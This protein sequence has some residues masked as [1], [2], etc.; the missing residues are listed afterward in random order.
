M[1]LALTLLLVP[2]FAHATG[3]YGL[4]IYTRHPEEVHYYGRDANCQLHP[5]ARE[6][7]GSRGFVC[8]TQQ[9]VGISA[10]EEA[11]NPHP[12][13]ASVRLYADNLVTGERLLQ[14]EYLRCQDIT[15]PNQTGFFTYRFACQRA[16]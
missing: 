4:L 6:A 12:P 16:R 15:P 11:P 5:M 13:F 10:I 14:T 3:D 9:F 2:G 1:K 7:A 8:Q